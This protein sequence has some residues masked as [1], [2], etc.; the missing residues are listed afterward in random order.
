MLPSA[1]T[2]NAATLASSTTTTQNASDIRAPIPIFR[3]PITSYLS[4]GS[5]VCVRAAFEPNPGVAPIRYRRA[6]GKP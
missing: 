2:P 3:K 4:F 6:A 5:V 1:D